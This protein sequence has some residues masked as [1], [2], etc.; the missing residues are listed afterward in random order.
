MLVLG[1]DVET[2]GLDAQA[3]RMTEVGAVLWDTETGAPVQ[4]FSPARS[5]T[6]TRVWSNRIPER[7]YPPASAPVSSS[8][9]SPTRTSPPRLS[10]MR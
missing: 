2:T 4:I 3:D 5:A 1:V 6:E 7:V 9:R 10:G 8:W